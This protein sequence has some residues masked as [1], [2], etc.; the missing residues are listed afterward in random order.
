ME[1]RFR[2]SPCQLY[3][4]SRVDAEEDDLDFRLLDSAVYPLESVMFLLRSKGSF[5]CCGSYTGQFFLDHADRGCGFSLPAFLRE[6][7]HYV[8]FTAERTVVIT[9][10]TAVASQ[11]GNLLSKE[12]LCKLYTMHKTGT[13]IECVERKLLDERA[14]NSTFFTSLPRTIGRTYGLLTLTIRLGML[15]LALPLSRCLRYWRYIFVIVSISASCLSEK[16]PAQGFSL[17]SLLNSLRIFPNRSNTRRITLNK[18]IYT[19][20]TNFSHGYL[21]LCLKNT[22]ICTRT[23]M[24]QLNIS[25]RRVLVEDIMRQLTPCGAW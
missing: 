4:I 23:I 7:S 5:H 13:L 12:F 24:S 20:T 16:I 8:L 15:S 25:Q 18:K 1:F 14:P 3:C 22:Y 6:W 2:S 21:Q 17:P 9:R 19:Y 11:F 10:I